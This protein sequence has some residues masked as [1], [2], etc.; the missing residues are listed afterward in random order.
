MHHLY[1][2]YFLNPCR[3]YSEARGVHAQAGVEGL[4]SVQNGLSTVQGSWLLNKDL[5]LSAFDVSD[6]NCLINL[7]S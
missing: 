6:N 4:K 3:S 1:S 5:H 7:Y 2:I